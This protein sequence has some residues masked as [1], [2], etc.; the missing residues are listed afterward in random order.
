VI[1]GIFKF[2]IGDQVWIIDDDTNNDLS[3]LGSN[4]NPMGYRV[5]KIVE[6]PDNKLTTLYLNYDLSTLGV[7]TSLILPRTV[8]TETGL[9]VVSY[10]KDS[11]WQSGIWTNGIFEGGQ[12]DSG[13]W[14]NGVFNGTWGN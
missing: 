2:N 13:I 8:P 14:Y 1:N 6:D 9:R 10:F 5:N 4:T 3:P 7:N 12:F 11:N